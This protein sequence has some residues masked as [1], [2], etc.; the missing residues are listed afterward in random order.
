[1]QEID[2]RA[3]EDLN[4]PSLVLMENAG[5]CVTEEIER[6]CGD[7]PVKVTSVCGPGNNGGDGIVAAR[8]LFELG[9]EALVF[10]TA[11][12]SS[13]SKDNRTQLKTAADIGVPVQSI[14][15]GGSLEK[16]RARLAESDFIV[17]ALFGTGMTRELTGICRK[18]VD[19]I[20]EA[21]GTVV[22]VDIPSGLNG[23]TG[24]PAGSAVMADVT[25]TF[26]FPKLG[27]AVFPGA[28][29]AGEVVVGDIG[30]PAV[31]S[32]HMEFEGFFTDPSH[33][34]KAFGPRWPDAHKGTYGHLLVVSGSIGRVGA[35][36]LA[37]EG[38]LRSGVGLVTLALPASSVTTAD[39]AAVEVMTEPLPETQAGTLANS[40]FQAVKKL[41]LERSALAIGP[42]LSVNDETVALVRDVLV[43]PGFPV[44][45][46]ADALNAIAGDIESLRS[47]N[48]YTVLTPHPGEMGRLLG[49]T[50]EQVQADRV[51]AARECAA[52]TAAVVVLKGAR[53]VIAEPGG[54]YY[55]NLTGNPG[56][57][58]AGSGDVLTGMI[59]ALLAR[60]LDPV[61]SSVA[62]VYLHGAAGDFAADLLTE[63]SMTAGD[64]LNEIG[65]ALK[66][67]LT[68]TLC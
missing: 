19:V 57:S 62:S 65:P 22:S 66:A 12:K 20:N 6:R 48:A 35:G 59:G 37:S 27:L 26:A 13:L 8:H 31:A 4:I 58:K 7:I 50:T 54:R 21:P 39:A 34:C 38:A 45:V 56:M 52:R 40:G 33:V 28:A 43:L 3:I 67:I 16:L 1:M 55:I 32:Q 9:H 60:G 42:G 11:P 10:L 68:E 29:Y 23:L 49:S 5:M 30:I 46:D 64:V 47:R 63:H 17:D 14:P 2:R 51:G 24:H 25:V 15:R 44:V 18:L 53:T 61:L 41:I 36:I